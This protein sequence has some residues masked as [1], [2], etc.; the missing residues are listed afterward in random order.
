MNATTK[1]SLH[2]A[3]RLLIDQKEFQDLLGCGHARAVGLGISAQVEH[4]PMGG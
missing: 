1:P 3:E 4:L 2:N